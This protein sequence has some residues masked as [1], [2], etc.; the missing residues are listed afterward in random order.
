MTQFPHQETE[1]RTRA[2]VNYAHRLILSGAP[3]IT[4]DALPG[5]LQ[6]LASAYGAQGAGIVA[7]LDGPNLFKQQSWLAGEPPDLTYPW[8]VDASLFNRAKAALATVV[9]TENADNH[10]AGASWLLAEITQSSY[11]N[12]VIWVMDRS[13]R[14]W[15]PGERAALP[16]VGQ[17]V[18]RLMRQGGAPWMRGLEK[19]RVQRAVEQ[20]VRVAR[21]LA[22][23][24]GNYLTGILGFTE[25][26]VKQIP[27]GSLPQ[28]YLKE[29]WQSAKDGASWVH[30]LQSLGQAKIPHFEPTDLAS[31]VR[32]EE[33]RVQS[34]C[35]NAVTVVT[36]VEGPLAPLDVAREPLRQV[37]AHLLDNAREAIEGQGVV[38]L[39]ARMVHL[40]PGECQVLLGSPKPGAYAEIAIT[41]TGIG[42]SVEM[43]ERLFADFFFSTK[44]RHR[45]LGLV[46]VFWIVQLYQGGVRF[47]PHPDQGTTVRVFLPLAQDCLKTSS[48]IPATEDRR[49]P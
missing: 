26:T 7:P 34:L 47:G 9:A 27:E 10:T 46:T 32:E 44:P 2:A 13:D 17:A 31:L 48:Q 42:L 1:D 3:S 20:A 23:D 45:G 39:T 49:I 19:V 21:R 6:E 12:F 43:H 30:K 24:F 22:H 11:A 29:V 5:L 15:S 41:D 16:I 25:L 33:S 40:G 28:R 38:R 8:E 36:H 37:L 35:G 18:T 4:D 14:T